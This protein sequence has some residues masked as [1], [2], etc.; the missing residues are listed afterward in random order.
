MGNHENKKKKQNDD[1]SWVIKKTPEGGSD[2]FEFKVNAFYSKIASF[3]TPVVA[4]TNITPNQITLFNFFI[5]TP[6]TAFFFSTGNYMWILVGILFFQGHWIL[7]SLDGSLARMKSMGSPM[8]QWLDQRTD[9]IGNCIL[10]GGVALGAFNSNPGFFISQI[11]LF[12]N[13]TIIVMIL[14][15]TAIFGQMFVFMYT[16]YLENK[17]RFSVNSRKIV[18]KF[19][20][21]KDTK[22]KE[23]LLL[24]ILIPDA[25]PWALFFGLPFFV[26]VGGLLNQLFF[27]LIAIA[28]AQTIRGA[29]LFYV[30]TRALDDKDSEML[31]VNIMKKLAPLK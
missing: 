22:M 29:L 1:Q 8:G 15:F 24:N 27:A 30:S 31:I 10:I 5:W 19:N 14:G 28:V 11:Y 6:L 2:Y 23:R 4:K 21:H 13:L 3:F 25:W 17:Y 26:I 18:Q 20:E 16:N 7:D 12:Y 9:D